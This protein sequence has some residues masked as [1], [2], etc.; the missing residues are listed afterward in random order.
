M[1]PL[2]GLGWT[3]RL[4]EAGG[5][6]ISPANA[7]SLPFN[8]RMKERDG[9]RDRRRARKHSQVGWEWEERF[10]RQRLEIETEFIHMHH[11]TS[12]KE[13]VA[14]GPINIFTILPLRHHHVLR[15]YDIRNK[16]CERVSI[17]V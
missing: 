5:C 11:A 16:R 15:L 1:A 12:I 13:L 17:V 6:C 2:R 9:R 7:G 10:G 8:K 4:L 3:V 14:R